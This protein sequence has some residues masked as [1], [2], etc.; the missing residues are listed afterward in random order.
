[1]GGR[2]LL[3]SSALTPWYIAE[4]EA[5]GFR[6]KRVGNRVPGECIDRVNMYASCWICTKVENLRPETPDSERERERA[7]SVEME[8]GWRL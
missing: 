3:R 2:V 6:G 5:H 1:M 7:G 8:E 4:F